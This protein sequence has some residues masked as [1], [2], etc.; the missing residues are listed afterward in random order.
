M[1]YFIEKR[2]VSMA[3]S[4]DE[5]QIEIN[6]KAAKANDAIDRLVVKL[7]RLTTSLGRVNGTNLNG[8]ANGVQRLGNAMQVMNTI[9]T[10][11]FTRLASNLTR[12]GSVNTSA[13]N[14][15]AS[16][17]SHLTRAFN[18]FS[19]VSFDNKNLQNMI[20]SITRLSNSNVQS[21][22]SVDFSRLGISINQLATSLSSAPKIQQS[23]ISMTNAIANLSKSGQNIPIVA[24]SLGSLGQSMNA[25]MASVSSAPNVSE[26]VIS[27]AQAVGLLANSGKNAGV[28][29]KNL[30][31]LGVGLRNLMVTLSK[32]PQ[33]SQNVIQMTNALA[34]LAS[35]GQSVG[36]ASNTITA[37]LNKTTTAT[38]KASNGFKGLASYIGKFYAKY[39]L[40]VR[41]IKKLWSSI[42]STADYIEAYNYFNVAMGKIGSDWSYQWEKYGYENAETYSKSFEKRLYESIGSLSGLNIVIGADGKGL[43]TESG[44][45]NLGLNIKEITQ[46]ASQLA[47]ITNSV[48]QTG[49]TSLAIS[50]TFT[51]LAGD[52]SSLFN[53]DYSSVAKNL[54]SGLIGQSRALYKYGIDITNATLQTKAYELGLSKAVSEMTQAEKMQLRTLA[55]LEQSKVSW[56]DL[57]NTINSPANLLRQFKNNLSET[58]MVFGQLFIPLMQSAMPVINGL[59]IALKRLLVEVAGFFGVKIDLDKFGQGYTEI[60]DDIDGIT[61]AYDDAIEAANKFK[62][63]TLGID[64]LNINSPQEDTSGSGT[65]IGGGIDL[66]DEILDAS[67]EYEKV[68]NEAFKQ[69]ENASNKWADAFEVSLSKIGKIA[70]DFA[71]GDFFSAGEDVSKLVID[72]NNFIAKAIKGIDAEAIGRNFTNFMLGI[73]YTGVAKSIANVVG[74]IF[75]SLWDFG[76]G[77][78]DALSDWLVNNNIENFWDFGKILGGDALSDWLIENN[79]KDFWDFGSILGGDALSDM[80]IELEKSIYGAPL[81]Y[82]D[83]TKEHDKELQDIT[84]RYTALNDQ[85]QRYVELSAN[86]DNLSEEEKSYVKRMAEELKNSGITENI[87]DIT[88]AWEGTEAE[89]KNVI[90]QQMNYIK[91]TASREYLTKLYEELGRLEQE[92]AKLF[93]EQSVLSLGG[94]I[95]YLF[96]EDDADMA[97]VEAQIESLFNQISQTE[98]QIQYFE[99]QI[100]GTNSSL[101]E[102]ADAAKIFGEAIEGIGFAGI[103]WSKN[104]EELDEY[105]NSLDKATDTTND[106]R[107]ANDNAKTSLHNLLSSP[108]CLKLLID[109]TD[110]NT[111]LGDSKISAIEFYNTF[112]KIEPTLGANTIP[113]LKGLKGAE[114]TWDVAVKRMNGNTPSLDVNTSKAESSISSFVDRATKALSSITVDLGVHVPNAGGADKN[115]W[116]NISVAAY[117]TGGF[118]EDGWFRASRGEIMGKFDNGQSVV[119]NNMQIVDGIKQGVKE[120]VSE[121]LAPYLADI[122]ETNREVARKDFSVNIG[123]REI[124]RANTRGQ[125]AMGYRLIT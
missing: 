57:A 44:V 35:Q 8:L 121:M 17:M 113:F 12:L 7:D 52:I 58:G 32:A 122:A 86:Y 45:Q 3:E 76:W 93:G 83:W 59:T 54:Q 31:S 43:L 72:L 74:N 92:K 94:Y 27:F 39:F 23:V 110:Y 37:G 78:G 77:I 107:G 67:S 38:Y 53:V 9:K 84:D 60:E 48:G 73:D 5:L 90:N 19:E 24:S 6:A 108:N 80:L 79:I 66:T 117:A 103:D 115:Q 50:S 42:E 63:T 111:K 89:L 4:I 25:F 100:N 40:V 49:E 125:K 65:G 28:T 20:N 97:S 64:E 87:N 75:T 11:D 36:A 18:A 85:A 120:A 15:A 106:F 71:I 82:I 116:A 14:S 26:N 2:G 10:A 109:N 1:A 61:G 114:D 98:S 123:D 68:W 70:E 112:G 88:G 51:K 47:S 33:V 41:S 22:A 101:D 46:Y 124:A 91:L 34:N 56:G 104:Q 102:G 55:I 118:P 16:S 62:S 13:L 95:K 29:A 96:G 30:S 81:K 119:A 105:I 99:N 21:L 69:M